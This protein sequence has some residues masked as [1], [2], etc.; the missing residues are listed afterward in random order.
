MVTS[1]VTENG[2]TFS[3]TYPST[4][5]G[6]SQST[7]LADNSSSSGG[8]L[9]SSTKSII[10][11]VAGGVGGVIVAAVLFAVIWRLRSRRR[12]NAVDVD[13]VL[14]AGRGYSAHGEKD[15]ATSSSPFK[16]TLESYHNP[17]AGVNPSSNF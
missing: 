4:T 17:A 11:G 13:D 2:S 5:S 3:S 10:G 7:S 8:G 12:N 15:S 9:S 6:S 14:M 1:V 16:S